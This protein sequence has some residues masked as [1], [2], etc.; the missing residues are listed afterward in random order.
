MGP[1]EDITVVPK[2]CATYIHYIE[3]VGGGYVFDTTKA[4][5]E[6]N[7]SFLLINFICFHICN[8]SDEYSDT[9][10]ARYYSSFSTFEDTVPVELCTC[11]EI[12]VVEDTSYDS[13]VP[14]TTVLDL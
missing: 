8:I 12:T 13:G 3:G 9:S 6:V 4:R 1:A 10:T 7:A 5:G 14:S 2:N 11:C